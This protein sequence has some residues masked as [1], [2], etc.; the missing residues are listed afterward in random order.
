MGA[1]EPFH[2]EIAL[3]RIV[4]GKAKV[5]TS[6][7]ITAAVINIH[8]YNR[9]NGLV[10]SGEIASGLAQTA[11]GDLARDFHGN[12]RGMKDPP[13]LRAGDRASIFPIIYKA[14]IPAP[15][16]EIQGQSSDRLFLQG[17]RFVFPCLFSDQCNMH[18]GRIPVPDH[19]RQT[20]WAGAGPMHKQRVE[21]GRDEGRKRQPGLCAATDDKWR[22]MGVLAAQAARTPCVSTA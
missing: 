22:I 5:P 21:T 8:D 3:A 14:E 13:C 16:R 11:A 1:L 4:L 20:I 12:R 17:D 18:P 7:R 15:L 2:R 6:H 10:D 19:I 9:G